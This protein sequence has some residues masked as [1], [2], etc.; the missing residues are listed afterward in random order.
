MWFSFGRHLINSNDILYFA[1]NLEESGTQY[2][3]WCVFKRHPAMMQSPTEEYDSLEL[4]RDR[5]K[6]LRRLLNGVDTDA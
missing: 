3:I 6:Q 1:H 5:L 2:E 4:V